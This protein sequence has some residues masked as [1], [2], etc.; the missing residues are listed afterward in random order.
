VRGFDRTH[1]PHRTRALEIFVAQIP[2]DTESVQDAALGGL[3]TR[4]PFFDRV[5]G[6][7]RNA[8]FASEFILGPTQCLTC[9]ANSIHGWGLRRRVDR[10]IIAPRRPGI[11]A[12]FW[13]QRL[14][15]AGANENKV[16]KIRRLWVRNARGGR[17]GHPLA[18]TRPASQRM[19]GRGA[20]A[21]GL[22]A[23][24][25]SNRAKSIGWQVGWA[26]GVEPP[27]SRTT[28]WRSNQLSYAHRRPGRLG[29]AHR[30]VNRAAAPKRPNR[31]GANLGI[32]SGSSG[33]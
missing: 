33:G 14:P 32:G 28:I 24:R 17:A 19:A 1:A 7:R 16:N 27:A 3:P 20:G 29:A 10:R 9:G 4:S 30:G 8:R 26:R 18:P 21:S 11:S 22:R 15:R 25:P 12:G 23:R 6:S 13:T 5:N 2:R 31:A